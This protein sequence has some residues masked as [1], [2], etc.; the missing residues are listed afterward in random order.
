MS[1]KM[2]PT[3]PSNATKA[4]AGMSEADMIKEAWGFDA[5]YDIYFYIVLRLAYAASLKQN[6]KRKNRIKTLILNHQK[7]IK[8]I[9]QKPTL[10][11]LYKN[12]F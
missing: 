4:V 9:C 7:L 2:N 5:S 3:A 11:K 10:S 6:Q 12:I 1:M 8:T